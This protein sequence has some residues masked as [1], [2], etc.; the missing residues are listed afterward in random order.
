MT[1]D[2]LLEE[3]GVDEDGQLNGEEGQYTVEIEAEVG[4]QTVK[5][6]P[7]VAVRFE[8]SDRRIVIPAEVA[9]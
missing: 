1:G 7:T 4:G 6:I 9:S 2:D 3:L 5:L 8:H